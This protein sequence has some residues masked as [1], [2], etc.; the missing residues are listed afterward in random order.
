MKEIFFT[1]SKVIAA[2]YVT[3]VTLLFFF[4]ERLIFFPQKL[5]K[6]HKFQ[7]NQNF[8]EVYA[9]TA[10]GI[11]I[12]GLLFKAKASKG[13]VYYLHGNAGS[14]QSWGEVASAYTDLNYDVFMIDYRGYGKSGGSIKNE[15]QLYEDVTTGYK[16]L[17]KSYT[18][19]KIIVLGYSL[20]SGLACKVASL[21]QPKMLVLQ[22]PYYS[23]VDMM[24]KNFPII[25]T[26]I[27][28]YKIK[29][30][31]YLATCD[32]PVAIFHGVQDEVIYFGSALKLKTDHKEKITLYPI[33][34]LG[35][36]GMTDHWE[37]RAILKTLLQ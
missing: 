36:N 4:Q 8:E 18:E 35:H 17:Q 24:R 28:K 20:G 2:L 27:L 30:H 7:F 21:N 11:Q 29:S 19:D 15:N 26:F 16:H 12:N 13:V 23:L 10:D 1:F 37:Y 9:T 14:L 22:S 33:E 32:M 3:L 31:A 34:D 6:N 25:P 5:N